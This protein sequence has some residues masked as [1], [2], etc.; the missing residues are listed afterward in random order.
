[1][2]VRMGFTV[3]KKWGANPTANWGEG[4]RQDD[5]RLAKSQFQKSRF[6]DLA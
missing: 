4:T 5:A 6:S 2:A 1:M 3:L